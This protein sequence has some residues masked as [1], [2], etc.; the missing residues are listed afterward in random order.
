M[1]SFYNVAFHE[2]THSTGHNERLN[3]P[4]AIEFGSPEYAKEELRAELGSMFVAA[5]I[6]LTYTGEHY[7]DHSNYM[8]SWISVL[9]NDP[10]ELYKALRDA[11]QAADYLMRGY[12]SVLEN[13]K[14]QYLTEKG[15]PY[16]K[17]VLASMAKLD[18]LTGRENTLEDIA[19]EYYKEVPSDNT[20]AGDLIKKIGNK[21]NKL[22]M[23][24]TAAVQIQSPEAA[25]T[26]AAAPVVDLGRNW[27]HRNRKG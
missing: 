25:I 15:Y 6:N 9:E 19:Q 16:D 2:M 1:T 26:P 7:Q 12:E 14:A 20:E 13:E 3:R 27:N 23:E 17:E 24:P 4:F 21:L 22:T 18:I 10:N 11:D 5:D 8:T